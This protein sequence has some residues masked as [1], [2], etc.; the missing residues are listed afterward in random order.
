MGV[1]DTLRE[2]IRDKSREKICAGLQSL[3][4]N[5]RMAALGRPEEYTG[6]GHSFGII[7]INDGPIPWISVFY[8]THLAEG[9]SGTRVVI[10][11][12]THYG[13]SVPYRPPSTTIK[14]VRRRRFRLLGKVIDAEWSAKGSDRDSDLVQDVLRRLGDDGHVRQAVIATRDVEIIGSGR[15]WV[16]STMTRD[17]PTGQAWECYQAIARHLIAAGGGA[18]NPAPGTDRS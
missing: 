10:I 8:T 15:G 14:S 5:A 4:V 12:Y 16:I 1:F 13:V 11:Y 17:V 3:G 9:T 18:G 7:D 2:R 6:P